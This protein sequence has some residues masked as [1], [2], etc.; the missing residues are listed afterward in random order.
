MDYKT[1]VFVFGSNEAGFHFD[2]AWK[3]W[4]GESEDTHY[5]GS[6]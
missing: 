1:A 2:E 5:W 4:L 6:K 3:P